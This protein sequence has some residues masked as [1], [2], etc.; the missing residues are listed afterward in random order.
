MCPN[1]APF[2]EAVALTSRGT[3]KVTH[4]LNDNGVLITIETIIVIILFA[5]FVA[6]AIIGLKSILNK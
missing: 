5:A 4:Q 6:L 2:F 1:L 3:S